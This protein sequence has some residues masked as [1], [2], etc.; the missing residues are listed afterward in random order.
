MKELEFTRKQLNR[1]DEI[2]EATLQMCRILT[3][4]DNLDWD[5]GIMGEIAEFAAAQLTRAGFKVSYPTIMM[6]EDGNEE[7]VLEY[8]PG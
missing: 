6:D 8:Y 7:Q 1:I 3:Q 5:C 4:D 2:D